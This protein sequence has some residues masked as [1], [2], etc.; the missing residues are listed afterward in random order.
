[1]LTINQLAPEIIARTITGESIDLYKMKGKKVLI[2][3]HR[4]S[5]CPVAQREI[6]EFAKR[7]KELFHAGIETIVF[8]HNSIDKVLPVFKEIPGLHLIADQ[9]KSFYKS[10]QAQ[11]KWSQLLSFASWRVTIAAIFHGYFPKFSKFQ[12]GVIG[13]PADFLVDEKSR[14]V[15]LHYGKHFGDSWTVSDVLAKLN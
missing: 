1:M 7:Q 8:L 15:D 4:F 6:S 9:E 12:G 11:F 14:I 13:I 5:G 10:Y 2:K 3:F